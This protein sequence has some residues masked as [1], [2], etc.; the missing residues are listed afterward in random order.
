MLI[1]YTKIIGKLH[2]NTFDFLQKLLNYQ[3]LFLI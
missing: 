3:Q 2:I 1:F